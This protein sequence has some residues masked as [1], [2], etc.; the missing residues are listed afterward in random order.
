MS[1]RTGNIVTGE[2]LLD[3]VKKRVVEIA[4]DP[5]SPEA[6]WDTVAVGAVK[7]A[8]L[9]NSIGQ[10]IVFDLDKSIS[11][12]GNSGPYL[13]YTYARAQSV[14]KKSNFQFSKFNFQNP[15][16]EEKA[17]LRYLY[18]FPEVV[19]SAGEAYDPSQIATYLYEL[20]Q[21]FNTFYNK[22]QILE[23]DFRLAMT[24]AVGQVVKN[25]LWLLGIK[26]P[27]KM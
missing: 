27:E 6:T 21:R 10:D 15:N 26:A 8:L 18:R 16:E 4:A 9:K 7:Y 3:E 1:S 2:W 13:Q 20:A 24:A 11:L 12:Q 17:I 5:T 14:L 23:N 25:G 22:H 19:M